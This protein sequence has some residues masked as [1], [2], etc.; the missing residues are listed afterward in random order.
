MTVHKLHPPGLPDCWASRLQRA[1]N[2]HDVVSAARDFLSELTFEEIKRL[3]E[4]CRPFR[5]V[6]GQDVTWYAMTLL[7]H[8]FDA[9]NKEHGLETRLATFFSEASV[10][11]AQVTSPASLNA[12]RESA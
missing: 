12:D 11:L 3:P 5:I 9:S 8:Q 2:E 7:R 10:R 4:I 6:D 1:S